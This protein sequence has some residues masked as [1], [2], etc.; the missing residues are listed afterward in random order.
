MRNPPGETYMGVLIDTDRNQGRGRFAVDLRIED[1]GYLSDH[2]F[3]MSKISIGPETV[4]CSQFRKIYLCRRFKSKV[5]EP[6]VSR[7][8]IGLSFKAERTE[9][10]EILP[11]KLIAL[12]P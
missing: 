1:V 10:G 4:N 9:T 11:S 5:L 8:E 12:L 6:V 7:L 2:A 3:R